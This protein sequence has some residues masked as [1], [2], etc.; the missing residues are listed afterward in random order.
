MTAIRTTSAEIDLGA[1]VANA[2][3]LARL[4]GTSIAAVLKADAYG[5]GAARVGLALQQAGGASAMA[6]S[7]IEEG[8]ELREV[9]ITIPILVL[10]PSM[11]GGH[12]D[13]VAHGL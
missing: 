3:A 1:V 9:G 2:V 8:I 12:R 13:L 10:G 7:L 11:S 5:H 4:A 6:V